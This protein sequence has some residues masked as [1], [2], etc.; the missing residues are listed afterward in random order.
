MVKSY[1][2]RRGD[3]N[4]G[5]FPRAI[6]DLEDNESPFAALRALVIN[7]YIAGKRVRRHIIRTIEIDGEADYGVQATV[8]EGPSG[9]QAFG[10]AY[11]TA[12]LEPV[13]ETD[14]D[15]CYYSLFRSPIRKALD[16]GALKIF[17]ANNR[18]FA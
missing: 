11:I 15:A 1:L 14:I 16:A 5:N 6:I 13:S 18:E 7:D 4:E 8:Y 9:E 12:E 17:R 10:A 2:Y 3:G